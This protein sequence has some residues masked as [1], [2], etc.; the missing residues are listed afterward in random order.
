[1]TTIDPT[2]PTPLL[3][4]GN[5]P[6]P[7]PHAPLTSSGSKW[8]QAATP[9]EDDTFS[10]WDFLDIVNPLQHIPIVS[11]LY[12]SV[13][14]DEIKAPARIIGGTLFGGFIGFAGSL[15]NAVIEQSS[16]SDIGGHIAAAAGFGSDG[17]ESD[18][19]IA[20]AGEIKLAAANGVMSDAGE[21]GRPNENGVT[22]QSA[23]RAY[24]AGQAARTNSVWQEDGHP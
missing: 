10:F 18:P 9:A 13:T 19:V 17:A 23:V 4:T 20:E 22:G 24:E 12:R 11:E 14:G 7:E 15:A 8:D 5:R 16:G 3:A 21:F 2:L 1:M 6:A